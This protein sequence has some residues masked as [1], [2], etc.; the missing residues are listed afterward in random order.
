MINAVGEKVDPS[1]YLDTMNFS[2]KNNYQ[3]FFI[4]REKFPK[5]F[6]DFDIF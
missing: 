5:V 4:G 1:T 6:N 3:I 2:N